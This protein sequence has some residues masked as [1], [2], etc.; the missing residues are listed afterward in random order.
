MKL[1]SK[2]KLAAAVSIVCLLGPVLSFA[3]DT[4]ENLT[5]SAGSLSISSDASVTLTGRTVTT[6]NQTSTGTVAVTASDLRGSGAG[7][8]ASVTATN[9]NYTGSTVSTSGSTPTARMGFSG[10]YNGVVAPLN[11]NGG[12]RFRTEITTAGAL[13]GTCKF[14][15][16]DPAG[17]LTSNVSCAATVSLSS[18]IT[19]T[20]TGSQTLGDAVSLIVG[21]HTY[22][23]N[24]ATPASLA[25]VNTADTTG[26]ALGSGSVFSGSGATSSANSALVAEAGAGLGSYTFNIGLSQ[27]VRKNSVAGAHAGTLTLTIA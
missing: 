5:L 1:I 7:F 10:S 23:E 15:W 18:G 19:A 17:S 12:G 2:S 25:A 27:T 11:S 21:S 26:V 16:L 6:S 4:T 24:T 14:K 8:T 13:D 9:I 3:S 22:T 20:F